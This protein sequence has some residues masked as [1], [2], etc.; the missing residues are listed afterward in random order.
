[1]FQNVVM[2]TLQYLFHQDG[3]EDEIPLLL[4]DVFW[5]AEKRK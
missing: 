1:M 3:K 4:Q 2:A 5:R